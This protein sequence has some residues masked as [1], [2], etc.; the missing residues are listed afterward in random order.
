[1][2]FQKLIPIPPKV[3]IAPIKLDEITFTG[4]TI[5]LAGRYN[6]YSRELS[7][8]PWV[9]GGKRLS[10]L[11]VEEIIVRSILPYFKVSESC[12]TFMSSGRED[13]DVRCLGKGRPFVLEIM[14]TTKTILDTTLA[15][16][17]EAEVCQSGVV[18]IRDVQLVKR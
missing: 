1:M 9:V 4:P 6:K 12:V 2:K 13:V 15:K 11:S 3:P 5:F 7:Q 16:K 17:M 14:N 18:S 8:T 10:D